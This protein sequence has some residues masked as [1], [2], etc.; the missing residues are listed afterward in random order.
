MRIFAVLIFTVLFVAT[1]FPAVN[2]DSTADSGA[3]VA[4]Q[5]ALK[6]QEKILLSDKQTSKIEALLDTYIDSKHP[7]HELLSTTK[8]KIEALL[9]FRQ[10]AKYDIIQKEWWDSFNGIQKEIKE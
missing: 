6:L 3:K 8:E 7:T 2:S 9:D 4:K 5:M 10:K 1:T